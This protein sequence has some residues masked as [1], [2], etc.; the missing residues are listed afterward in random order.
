MDLGIKV[1]KFPEFKIKAVLYDHSNSIQTAAHDIISSRVEQQLNRQ[2]AYTTLCTG[3][4]EAR[5]HQ[6]ATEVQ[7]WVEGTVD[8][9]SVTLNKGNLNLV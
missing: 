3:L 6:L 4:K 7:Q 5:M 9:P 1:L 2:E 8:E